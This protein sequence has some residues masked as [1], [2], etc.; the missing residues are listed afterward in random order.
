MSSATV[1]MV[2]EAAEPI[3]GEIDKIPEEVRQSAKRLINDLYERNGGQLHLRD[4]LREA[5]A[6]QDP[7]RI[8]YKEK[9]GAVLL[10]AD[11]FQLQAR[12][13]TEKRTGKRFIVDHIPVRCLTTDDRINPR[14]LQRPRLE[15]LV[16]AFRC[17]Q[18]R[19]EVTKNRL[20]PGED[21]SVVLAVFDGSHGTAAEILADSDEV[22]CKVYLEAE[23]SAK[24]AFDW[25]V[26][27]HST[28]RQQEFRSRVLMSRRSQIFEAEFE[29]FLTNM[30]LKDVPKSE[31]GF[32]ASQAPY[33]RPLLLESTRD[34][35]Y[36]AALEDTEEIELPDATTIARPRCKIQNFVRKDE[37][38]KR[39]GKMLGYDLLK[40]TVLRD[41]V[42]QDASTKVIERVPVEKR[43]RE[44][45]RLNLVK[46]CNILAE[47]TLEGRWGQKTEPEAEEG[48]RRRQQILTSDA[49]RAE[50]M[51][52][53]GA[54]RVWCK[55]LRD[56]LG[57]ILGLASSDQ[58]TIFQRDI[59]GAVW[60][61]VRAAVRKIY[62]YDAWMSEKVEPLLGGNVI[63]EIEKSLDEWADYN[64]VPH[65]D[66]YSLA[67]KD[68]P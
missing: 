12:I 24:D 10:K 20:L 30:Q 28:L 47:E 25:N 22:L 49:K 8:S 63:G 58:G 32:L 5:R 27:A 55:R 67:G 33:R 18:T 21:G 31:T 13:L 43:P 36:A 35:V 68:R 60:D 11:D 45:E 61:Q 54:V 2:G 59:S 23:L 42:Q 17:G 57:L 6:G 15:K 50:N 66:A 7:P 26:E 52:K 41:F 39:G 37:Q 64:G 65:L 51:W 3:A 53:K 1:E 16:E 34:Y 14:H 29:D 9:D 44:Q 62:A 48:A 56:A 19:F 46:L 40:A 38:Q 4:V